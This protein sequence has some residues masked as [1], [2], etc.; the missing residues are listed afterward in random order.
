MR[1]GS[2][3]VM[4]GDLSREYLGNILEEGD[5]SPPRIRVKL[6][7]CHALGITFETLE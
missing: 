4:I 1:L 7:G 3:C 2:A 5:P 6:L